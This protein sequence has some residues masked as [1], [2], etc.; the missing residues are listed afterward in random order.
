MGIWKEVQQFQTSLQNMYARQG[1]SVILLETVLPHT[2]GLWQ[3]KL[4]VVPVP[5][6]TL[7]DAPIYFQSAMLE[8]T[9]E[10]GTH[11]KVLKTSTQKPLSAVIPKGFPYF[12]VEWG[13]IS[14]SPSATGYAQIIESESFQHDFGLD[15][16]AGMLDLDPVRLQRKQTYSHEEER[17]QIADFL[18]QWDRVDW[19]KELDASA[20]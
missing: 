19:T 6:A 18:K 11:N 13:K 15:T 14:T 7:Q 12:F 20:K 8:Q 1:K 16:V 17:K 2:K 9:E 3:T 10:W 4:E 5:F